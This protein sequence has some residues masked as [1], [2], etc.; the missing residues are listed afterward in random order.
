MIWQWHRCYCCW[1]GPLSFP[2]SREAANIST[3]H[4]PSPCSTAWSW[5]FCCSTRSKSPT[6]FCKTLWLKNVFSNSKQ[7]LCLH[8]L[9]VFASNRHLGTHANFGYVSRAAGSDGAGLELLIYFCQLVSADD[10][11]HA[12][13]THQFRSAQALVRLGG[14][15]ER[16]DR[17]I[18]YFKKNYLRWLISHA[19]KRSGSV[20]DYGAGFGRMHLAVGA[21]RSLLLRRSILLH[22]MGREP[23]MAQQKK[24]SVHSPRCQFLSDFAPVGNSCLPQPLHLWA[25]EPSSKFD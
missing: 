14:D 11:D 19:Q 20:D 1:F 8:K 22:R 24:I 12:A 9:R 18:R 23:E 5:S 15:G 17:L 7:L 13:A 21:A 16:Y 4:W 10:S 2:P 25:H 3:T 6:Q